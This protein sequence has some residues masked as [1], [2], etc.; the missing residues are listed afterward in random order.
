MQKKHRAFTLIELL[1][2]IA[3]IALLIA[4]LLPAVQAAREAARATQCR[5]NLKQIALALHNYHDRLRILPSGWTA[6]P[7]WQQQGWGWG[8]MILPELEQSTLF[9]KLNFADAMASPENLR[10]LSVSVTTFVCPSDP[11]PTVGEVIV[12]EPELRPIGPPSTAWF[13]PPPPKFFQVAKSNYAAHFGSTDMI[14]D[15]DSGNGM[16][17]RNSGVRFRDVLDGTSQTLMVG[18]RRTSQRQVRYFTGDD[19]TFV[20]L[21][22]MIGVLPWCSDSVARVVGSGQ[23]TPTSGGRS[24]PGFNSQHPGG[25]LFGLADGSVRSVSRNIDLRV[26]QALASRSG[27]E[28]VGEF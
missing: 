24:F 17:A 14:S 20:D 11:F 19:L 7:K 28:V 6:D 16:F 12:Q 3:I 4:L 10:L 9:Q 8:A 21:T 25:V 1:V 13:H 5:N 22:L 15:P 23:Q 18:E 26:Y 2:V 27:G